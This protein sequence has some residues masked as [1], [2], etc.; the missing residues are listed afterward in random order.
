M[1]YTENFYLGQYLHSTVKKKS[2]ALLW[3][4]VKFC[5]LNKL[6]WAPLQMVYYCYC[7]YF[8][9]SDK[10][11]IPSTQHIQIHTILFIIIM[12]VSNSMNA[13]KKLIC[14]MNDQMVLLLCSILVDVVK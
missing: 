11:T 3:D 5:G 4:Q 14:K 7:C 10:Y 1:F 2:Q 13:K 9:V 6:A 8:K 12:F